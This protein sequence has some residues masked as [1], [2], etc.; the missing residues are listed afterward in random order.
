MA[1]KRIET[2]SVKEFNEKLK[3][4]KKYKNIIFDSSEHKLLK[5][6]AFIE[7]KLTWILLTFKTGSKACTYRCRKDGAQCLSTITGADAY[8]IMQRYYKA[9]SFQD[10]EYINKALGWSD[11]KQDYLAS[12]KPLLWKNDKFEATRN[13]AY[14][15]DLNSSYSNALLKD[16]PDTNV[17]YRQ[18]KVG[19]GEVGFLDTFDGLIPVFEG[20][21][22][23]FIFPLIPSPYKK[24]VEHWYKIKKE[25][26]SGTIEHQKA[27]DM[28][29]F[30]IGYFQKHNPFMRAMVIYYAN[31]EIRS[32]IDDNTLYCNTDSIVSLTERNDLNI[33]NDIGQFKLEDKGSYFA[34]KGYNYQWDLDVPSYRGVP[35]KW[36]QEG[37]DILKDRVPP[38][39]NVYYLDK[40][41]FELKE[42]QNVQTKC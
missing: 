14:S 21:Y 8:I 32:K 10:D 15:Y 35:K 22:S 27:K 28:L 6:D 5:N 19:K 24:Y 1:R 40:K 33:G 12:A 26:P 31:E 18:G 39:G 7:D 42:I 23:L 20:H 2:V 11:E 37:W 16:L 30:P 9:K 13:R 29:N 25:T 38:E 17:P 41:A 3:Y 4:C 34:F 36:F